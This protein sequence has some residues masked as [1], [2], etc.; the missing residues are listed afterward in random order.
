MRLAAMAA[1]RRNVKSDASATDA[2]ERRKDFLSGPE[3]DQL[4]EAAKKGRHAIRDY[5]LLL[6]IYRH[7]LRVSEA[8]QMRRGQLAVKRSRLWVARLKNSLS[9]EQ[10]VA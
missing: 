1:K 4:L 8:I 3:I 9:V 5:A 6:M 2:H 10:P 7:G